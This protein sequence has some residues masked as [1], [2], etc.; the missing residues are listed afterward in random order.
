MVF[1]DTILLS[2]P[3]SESIPESFSDDAALLPSYYWL[4]FLTAAS[5]LQI[6]LFEAGLPVRG[7]IEY[8]QFSFVT[9]FTVCIPVP[10]GGYIAALSFHPIIP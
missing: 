5:S 3:F 9:T 2:L 10:R 4:A 1:S 8:G 6:K 7:A